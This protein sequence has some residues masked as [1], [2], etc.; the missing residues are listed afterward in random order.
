MES[1]INSFAVSSN[2]TPGFIPTLGTSKKSTMK[3]EANG[4]QTSQLLQGQSHELEQ[5][6]FAAL[7]Q[8]PNV[9]R[10]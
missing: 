1:P 2:S 8:V 10:P 6:R 3:T 4:E 5:Q 9:E 7:K